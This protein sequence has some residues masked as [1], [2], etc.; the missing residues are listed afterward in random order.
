MS[1]KT[2]RKITAKKKKLI[3]EIAA[4]TQDIS[5]KARYTRMAKAFNARI[6]DP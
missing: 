2:L 3:L 1:S 5:V 4:N 6:F